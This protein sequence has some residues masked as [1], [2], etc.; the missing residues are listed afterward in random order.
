MAMSNRSAGV[1]NDFR[2][3]NSP[4]FRRTYKEAHHAERYGL[5]IIDYWEDAEDGGQIIEDRRGTMD[6]G[7]RF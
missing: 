3:E 6:D 1:D 4:F 2:Y 5:V 7:G